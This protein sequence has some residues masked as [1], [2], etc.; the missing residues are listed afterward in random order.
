MTAMM[1]KNTETTMKIFVMIL[2]RHQILRRILAPFDQ[3]ILN[4]PLFSDHLT[5]ISI[6]TL[7]ISDAIQKN[8]NTKFIDIH[9]LRVIIPEKKN[10][11]YTTAKV[12]EKTN[13][14]RV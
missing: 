9:I 6:L 4:F 11:Q 13:P 8:P 5:E 12:M 3:N 1:K 10:Q 2:P 14:Q 7:E